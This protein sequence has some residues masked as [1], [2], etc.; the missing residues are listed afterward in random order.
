[1]LFTIETVAYASIICLTV[2]ALGQWATS[3]HMHWSSALFGAFMVAS[4]VYVTGCMRSIAAF[5]LA[6]VLGVLGLGVI[7]EMKVSAVTFPLTS[8]DVLMFLRSPPGLLRSIGAPGAAYVLL[9]CGALLLVLSPA[10]Y[11]AWLIRRV[12]WQRFATALAR[13]MVALLVVV[14]AG[15]LVSAQIV[16]SV[17][18]FRQ[19]SSFEGEVITAEGL[20]RFSRK[21]GIVPFIIYWHSMSG[22]S[23]D[24]YLLSAS[25]PRPAPEELTKAVSE[26]AQP[27]A[28]PGQLL[29]NIILVHAE[30]TFDPNAVLKLEKT[31]HNSLFHSTSDRAEDAGVH[32]HALGLANV[33]GGY[34]WV[35]EFE[36][37]LGIDSRMFGMDG[38][39]AHASLSHLA[40]RTFVRYLTE[41][42]Y[43]TAAYLLDDAQFYNYEAAYRNYGFGEVLTGGQ[44]G[45]PKHDV[46]TMSTV[47][48][49][50]ETGARRPFLAMVTLLGNHSPHHCPDELVPEN[51]WIN[52]SGEASPEQNCAINE[53][54]QRARVTEK[55]VAMAREFLKA[56]EKR[57]GRPY[58]LAVYGD[59]QPYTFTG[60]GSSEQNLGLDFT[61]LRKDK[62]KRLT[63]LKIYS[64]MTNPL[65]NMGEGPVPLTSLPSLISLYVARSVE[66][67]YLPE[68]FYR[69]KHCGADW[70]GSL[71]RTMYDWKSEQVPAGACSEYERLKASYAASGVLGVDGTAPAPAVSAAE[72]LPEVPQAGHDC[73]GPLAE[74]ASRELVITAAG[75]MFRSP[76][77]FRVYANGRQIGDG[78]IANAIDTAK[79]FPAG[80][81][82]RGRMQNYVFILPMP[83]SRVKNVEIEFLN[84]EWQG[85]DKP[86][87]SNLYV[88]ALTAGG[89]SY[90][91]LRYAPPP[92]GKIL[93]ERKQSRIVFVQNAKASFDVCPSAAY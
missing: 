35:S 81:P 39:Y 32:V 66:D 17:E 75:T 16:Q 79:A 65:K 91:I 14:V 28:L 82:D 25:S 78:V 27:G 19:G 45:W 55:A 26:I 74:P 13:S 88:S 92:G 21:V 30:S 51:L 93:F 42:G 85:E 18:A 34:S 60:N 5:S 2:V 29:P 37:L 63:I 38:L 80:G 7:S 8:F 84:D 24:E 72:K 40:R 86:G 76:P 31:A 23:A 57:T 56:E 15:K 50:I 9:W 48:P 49:L 70:V 77:R 69:Q 83:F 46:Q 22:G 54:L 64:S 71:S 89:A 41:H 33:I 68:T 61:D 58:V 20:E 11:S 12:G 52:L 62:D 1:M 67:V 43:D 6:Y 59:H 3:L 36:V 90:P 53:Y 73:L 87:D 10:A 47:L 44:L 4:A